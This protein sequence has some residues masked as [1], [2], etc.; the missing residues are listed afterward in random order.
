MPDTSVISQLALATEWDTVGK[1]RRPSPLVSALGAIGYQPASDGVDD[2]VFAIT[3]SGTTASISD[4]VL[5]SQHKP[6]RS[7]VARVA[8]CLH[9]LLDDSPS[10]TLP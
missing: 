6:G 5:A 7:W 1:S 9:L 10:V 3:Q 8:A 4:L 2:V